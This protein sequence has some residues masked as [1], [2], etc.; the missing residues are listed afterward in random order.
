MTLKTSERPTGF[1]D[2]CCH[3]IVNLGILWNSTIKVAELVNSFKWFIDSDD[4]IGRECPRARLVDY[5]CLSYA[6]RQSISGGGSGKV[7]D[8]ALSIL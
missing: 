8:D 7:I 3:F 5:L 1:A 6:D 4:R 2:V